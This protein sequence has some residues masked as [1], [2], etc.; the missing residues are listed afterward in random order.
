[1]SFI[2]S[3]NINKGL[4][5]QI[6]Q[7]N[8]SNVPELG[9][10]DNSKAIEHIISMCNYILLENNS[11]LKGFLLAMRKNS[12]YRS[13][14]FLFFKHRYLTDFIYVDRVVVHNSYRCQGIGKM[15]YNALFQLAEEERIP[16][17]CEVN[18]VPMNK[19]SMDFHS[20]MGFNKIGDKQYDQNKRVAY[21]EKLFI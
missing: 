3:N 21:L 4:I 17:C 12:L 19:I 11:E 1:M 18:E 2:N 14:N 5:N 6:W 9:S 15:F 10:V 8:Q 13:P 7:L 20:S 16:I